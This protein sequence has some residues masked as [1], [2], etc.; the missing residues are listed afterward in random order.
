MSF[1]FNLGDSS[2][3]FASFVAAAEFFF[4][5][6]E[7]SKERQR[8]QVNQKHFTNQTIILLFFQNTNDGKNTIKYT[9]LTFKAKKKSALFHMSKFFLS[10]KEEITNDAV[11]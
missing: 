7:I 10:N 6:G 5:A 9:V 3:L 4:Q 8:K 11:T 2:F 1:A